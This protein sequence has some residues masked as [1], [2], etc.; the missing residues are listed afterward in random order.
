MTF[1]QGLLAGANELRHKAHLFKIRKPFIYEGLKFLFFSFILVFIA[2]QGI[3][4]LDYRWQWYRMPDY[5]YKISDS[6]FIAGPLFTGLGLT[7]LISAISLIL[8]NLIGFITALFRLS[9]SVTAV[10]VSRIYLE[11]VRN[12]P[13]LI[14]LFLVYFVI[15]PILGIGRMVSAIMALSLFEG[16]YTS[17][18]I[19]SG[20]ISIE[21]GQWEAAHSI[22]LTGVQTYRRIILPQAFGQ[23]MPMLAS[24]SISLVKDSALISTIAIYELTMQGQVAI[25]KSFLTFEVWFSVAAIYLIINICLSMIIR[26]FEQNKKRQKNA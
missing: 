21:K 13:L 17:E 11:V 1:V 25:S 14:Q 18:I 22:G 24:Q 16:A 4:G 7:L 26:I 15:S 5:F 12:T 9:D 8:S 6:G 2:V 20:I 19:R 3:N 23:V 10:A